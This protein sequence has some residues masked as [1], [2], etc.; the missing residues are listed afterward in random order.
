MDL[1]RGRLQPS[2]KQ[3]LLKKKK[4]QAKSKDPRNTDPSKVHD[5]SG[6]PRAWIS[7][8]DSKAHGISS[9][10]FRNLRHSHS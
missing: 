5:C 6:V 4:S 8:L 7:N 1:P 10:P 3:G 2:R 9:P